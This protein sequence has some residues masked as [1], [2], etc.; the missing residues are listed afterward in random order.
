[1]SREEPDL[2]HCSAEESAER[3]RNNAK[4]FNEVR[5]WENIIFDALSEH[6][7]SELIFEALG[8][9]G[10]QFEKKIFIIRKYTFD[11]TLAEKLRNVFGVVVVLEKYVR[12]PSSPGDYGRYMPYFTWKIVADKYNWNT[13]RNSVMNEAT[14]LAHKIEVDMLKRE[15][16]SLKK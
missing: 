3:I 2:I 15:I 1:M 9:I 10:F 13:N 12:P 5:E 8:D 16:K 6:N 7:G 11:K 14:N 4:D